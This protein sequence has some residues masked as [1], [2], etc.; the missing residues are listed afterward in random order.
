MP[1]ASTNDKGSVTVTKDQE[2]QITAV[3][4]LRLEINELVQSA[5]EKQNAEF[6]RQM[7]LMRTSYENEK[8][9]VNHP[10]AERFTNNGADSL[11]SRENAQWNDAKRMRE[12]IN[13]LISNA[14]MK[15]NAELAR[16]LN[17]IRE[18]VEHGTAAQN[19]KFDKRFDSMEEEIE[20]RLTATVIGQDAIDMSEIQLQMSEMTAS[21]SLLI[22]RGRSHSL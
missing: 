14:A 8:R 11:T 20:E 15:Q 18:T 4:N 19:E 9:P 2:G 21:L 6:N 13:A 5:V 22:L 10:N 1:G 3:N 16:Q 17:E 12:E 7:S